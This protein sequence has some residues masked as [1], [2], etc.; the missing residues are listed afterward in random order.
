MHFLSL[1]QLAGYVALVLGVVAFLQREDRRLKQMIAGECLAYVIHFWLLGSLPAA[2]GAFVSGSRTL[3]SLKT[4][5]RWVAGLVILVCIFLGLVFSRG[6]AG[7]LPLISACLGTI[8]VFELK[9]VPM[10]LLLLGCTFLWLA[11]NIICG[12]I[13]GVVLES[14]LALANIFTLGRLF[15]RP[16]AK[17]V[18]GQ[19]LAQL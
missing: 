1:A 15:M 16:S 12:S 8:A 18:P 3:L 2:L 19:P 11:N 17:A 4:R 9:G 13:G 5:S 7:W 10:R 6:A 14:L